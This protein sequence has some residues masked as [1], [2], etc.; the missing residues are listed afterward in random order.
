MRTVVPVNVFP[1]RVEEVALPLKVTVP[2]V[3]EFPLRVKG[4]VELTLRDAATRLEFVAVKAPVMVVVILLYVALL[5]RV[6]LPPAGMVT[7]SN[8]CMLQFCVTP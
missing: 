6:T 3:K 1:R 4:A 7:G 2:P 8:P 5:T